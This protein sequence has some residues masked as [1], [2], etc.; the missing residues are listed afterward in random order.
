MNHFGNPMGQDADRVKFVRGRRSWSK[1]EED[2]LILCLTNVV[3]E[4][5]KSENGFKA[6]FQRELEKG[7]IEIFGKDRATGE[8][9]V[10]PIDLINELYKSGIDQE[11][12]TGEKY[13]PLTPDGMH[14]MDDNTTIKPTEP[15]LKAMLKG[16][17]RE[18]CESGITLLVESLG[19]FMKYSKVAMTDLSAG[20]EKG[21]VSSNEN[22]Q[23]NDI[24]KCIV[25]LKVSEKLKACDK[26]VQNSECLEFF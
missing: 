2:A 17:K 7:W 13:M 4:G 16:K 23:L 3:H 24:M 12:E 20:V 15:N 11:G 18:K 8:N 5:W 25:G 26:L 22:K 10:D 1:I 9:V 14:D 6:G 21:F 19:E